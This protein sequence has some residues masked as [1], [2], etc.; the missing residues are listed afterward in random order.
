MGKISIY[1]YFG[2]L[3]LLHLLSGSL[4]KCYGT[5]HL[6]ILDSDEGNS[7]LEYLQMVRF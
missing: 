4:F 2:A 7:E 6:S 3:R 5:L 1:K